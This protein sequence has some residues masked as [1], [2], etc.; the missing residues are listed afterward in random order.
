MDTHHILIR[1]TNIWS[2]ILNIPSDTIG[3]HDNFFELG[4]TSLHLTK[5][6]LA[7]D[8]YF[9]VNIS[10]TKIF[11]SP[12]ISTLADAIKNKKKIK[13]QHVNLYE[14]L[15]EVRLEAQFNDALQD[16][17]LDNEIQKKDFENGSVVSSLPKYIFLTGVTGFLGIHLLEQLIKKT[18]AIIYCLIRSSDI[19]SAMAKVKK[20]LSYYNLEHLDIRG[21]V[22]FWCGDL[23]KPNLGLSNDQFNFLAHNVDSI[24]HNGAYVHHI[25]NYEKLRWTNVLSTL[26]LLR[27]ATMYKNKSIYYISTLSC[28][29]DFDE[30]G[31]GYEKIP[32]DQPLSSFGG[33]VLTKWVSESL[34]FQAY[35]RGINTFIYRPGNITGHSQTGV[36]YPDTNHALLFI[37]GCIQMKMAP[38]LNVNIEMMPVDILSKA[39]VSFS[40]SQLSGINIYNLANINLLNWQD[41]ITI[42]N[43]LGF[44]VD[45]VPYDVWWKECISNINENNALF[46]L[47]TFYSENPPDYK[48]YRCNNSQK[49]FQKLGLTYPSDYENLISVYFKYLVKKNFLNKE[50][51]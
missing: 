49:N 40:L 17:L 16:A 12:T 26:E 20:S 13:D 10:F 24:Y 5:M 41:Y 50:N 47:L 36:C 3:V 14:A 27:M 39:I 2:E 21:H 4:G 9:G 46:P 51:W 15:Q 33:Y 35:K 18:N 28:V 37:K 29:C 44:C 48:E 42:I 23:A 25:Y 1:L 32:A 22:F 7:V 30:H 45:L 34:L 6:T 38:Q 11:A 43:Q 8:Q 31:Y 19:A